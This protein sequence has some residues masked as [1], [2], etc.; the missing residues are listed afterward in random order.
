MRDA[1]TLSVADCCKRATVNERTVRGWLTVPEGAPDLPSQLVT[2]PGPRS[3]RS[4]YR[5]RPV[6]L[7]ALL[8]RI[9]IPAPLPLDAIRPQQAA[10]IFA[11]RPLPE[12]RDR[13][14]HTEAVHAEVERGRLIAYE[15]VGVTR[16]SRAGVER[17]AEER[18]GE[19]YGFEPAHRGRAAKAERVRAQREKLL[20]VKEFAE[21]SGVHKATAYRWHVEERYGAVRRGRRRFFP[22]ALLPEGVQGHASPRERVTVVCAVCGTEHER[23]ASEVRRTEQ[24]QKRAGQPVQFFCSGCLHTEKARTLLGNPARRPRSK[25]SAETRQRRGKAIA[26]AWTPER[27]A[28]QAERMRGRNKD[29][30]AGDY[31][32]RKV[33]EVQ[34]RYG[35]KRTKKEMLDSITTG[36]STKAVRTSARVRAADDRAREA[37]ALRE[38]GLT[39][40]EICR[41]LMIGDRQLRNYFREAGLPS[42]KRGR[43]KNR[44]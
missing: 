34:T 32:D 40:E 2:R 16:Y 26:A 33:K 42:R 38:A 28:E 30:K 44:K 13:E 36:R 10:E 1:Y 37:V 22:E 20:T 27:K 31:A 15:L 14:R 19:G 9:T 12:R 7:E 3:G 29:T 39:D 21:R 11:G 8:A 23:Y 6:D 43:P 41:K 24:R 5:V 25:P 35:V 18:R 17:V 4:A